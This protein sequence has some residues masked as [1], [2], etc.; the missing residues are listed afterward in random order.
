MRISHVFEI[1][2]VFVGS[3][4]QD[5]TRCDLRFYAVH[6]TVK[7]FHNRILDPSGHVSRQI[8]EQ[9]RRAR[10]SAMI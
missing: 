7:S 4:I 8:A 2:G 1:D 9:F 3:L 10:V 5:C 6:E